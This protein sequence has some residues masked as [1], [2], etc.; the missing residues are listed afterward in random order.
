M[1]R[2]RE[3]EAL[4][5]IGGQLDASLRNAVSQ[6]VDRLS[7][8]S[9]GTQHAADAV[10]ELSSRMDS[11]RAAL[12]AA[13]RQYAS[14]IL[15][16]EQGS[17][18]ARELANSIQELSSDLNLN[19]QHMREAQTAAR[20]L[21]QGSQGAAD[22]VDELSSRM[23]SQRAALQAAQRQYA[24]YILR[25][26]QGSQEARELANSIQELSS[27]LN[28]N[29]Q[30]MRYAQNATQ[31]LSDSAED[32]SEGFT[33]MKGAIANL[34]GNGISALI[35]KCADAV[36][37]LYDLAESTREYREDMGKL[38]TAWESA[39]KSTEL[40]TETYKQFYG[41]LGEEDRSV[42]A[43]NHLAKFVDTE[44][45]LTKWTNI[46]A[47]VWGTFGDSLP[48]EGLTEASNETAKVSK[49]TGVLADALNWAGISEDAMN[50]KLESLSTE[51][52]RSALI[53][54]VLNSLYEDAAEKYRENNA[55]IIEA[56]NANSDYM[57]SLA[58]LGERMEP[59]TTAVQEGFTQILNKVLELTSS[60][61]FNAFADQVATV[62]DEVAGSL[63]S[64]TTAIDW[65]SEH[66]NILIPLAAG[67]TGAFVAYQAATSAASIASTVFAGIEAVKASALAAGT[68]MTTAQAAATW[69]LNG[70]M[71]VLTSPIFLVAAAIGVLIAIGVA[72]WQNWDTVKLKAAELWAKV[73]ETFGGI[74]D[75]IAGAF[76]SAM[77]TVGGFFGWIGDKL[78]WLSS[79][80]ESI[81]VIGKLYGGAKD[82]IGGLFGGGKDKEVK[83]Y[84]KGGFTNGLSIAGEAGM[85]AVISFDP[86]YR[87][88]NISYWE[89]AGQLLG[90]GKRALSFVHS[91]RFEA[92]RTLVVDDVQSPLAR[93]GRMLAADTS[94]ISLS[95]GVQDNS[96]NLGGVTFAP[97]ITVT[98]MTDR[99][100]IM[101]AIEAE[102][103]A[104]MD[105]LEEWWTERSRPVYG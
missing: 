75:A 50:E 63:D 30:R 19:E 59:V 53:T 58:Q 81:P 89:K 95:G 27:D 91:E 103:P 41:V 51:Q 36:S 73:T 25:N 94:G 29:E 28:R 92:I 33:V 5:R 76:Q 54:E 86:R 74:R 40:A 48:I 1:A 90:V 60:G 18:E 43:V 22:A 26:E 93:A 37:N 98:G 56:R 34:I 12:Q 45:D 102:Y 77:D 101:Q 61:D 42:E 3:L 2:G 79:K 99:Q 52:E 4:I 14:Y 9:Q 17:Q 32:A 7:N 84:A 65:V 35:G 47:G 67:L 46:A 71:A 44:A 31:D 13:Q 70:A 88:Q 83:A 87:Q 96:I 15:R 66:A 55:S 100:S 20:Q 10:D 24:S 39:N 104:F 68:T 23:D 78:S 105:L 85:E 82:A 69:A 49:V 64:V 57:D 38:E 21:A 6:A 97:K 72:L 11:Q 62:F 16:N 80:I 8:M